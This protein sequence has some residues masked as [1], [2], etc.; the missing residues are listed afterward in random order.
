VDT[1]VRWPQYRPA[2]SASG[3][4]DALVDSLRARYLAEGIDANLFRGEANVPARSPAVLSDLRPVDGAT[5]RA[6]GQ[7]ALASGRVAILVMAGGMATRFGGG[8]KAVVPVLPGEPDSSFLTIKIADAVRRSPG[9]AVVVMHSPATRTPILEHLEAQGWCGVAPDRRYHFGQ[10]TMP[11]LQEDGTLA[12]DAAGLAG[13]QASAPAGHGDA[14]IELTNSG[15]L[16]RLL[17]AGVETIVASNVDNLGATVDPEV[18]GWHLQ[19]G[20]AVTAEVIPRRAGEAGASV[21]ERADGRAVILEDFRLPVA[22]RDRF[23]HF[24]INTLWMS[25]HALSAPLPLDWFFVPKR[26]SL[27]GGGARRVIQLER[28]I[29]QVAEHLPTTF[30]EVPEHRFVPIKTPADLQLHAEALGAA[31]R[32]ARTAGDGG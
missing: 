7:A 22:A 29:G 9:M 18:L 1:P 16:A 11:R 4:D 30:L 24:S 17:A 25:A 5:A 26:V 12:S 6:A 28:L 13:D 27:P 2:V 32:R 3:D 20:G 8:A 15:V 21:V 14:A 10:A 23:P 31:V 19:R